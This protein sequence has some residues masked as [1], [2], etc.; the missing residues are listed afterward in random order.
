[1][2]DRLAADAVLLIH[3]GFVVFVLLGGFLVW[4]WPKLFWLH[5]PAMVWGF[6]VEAMGWFCPLTDIENHFRRAAG[7]AGYEGGFI[8]HY[9]VPLLYPEGLTRETQYLF[10]AIVV[11]VN[12]VV[13]ARFLFRRSEPEADGN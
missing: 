2:L 12:L 10:A 9:L 7:Q 4:R 11:G 13:Y 3:L 8:E 1:M 6:L 5:L